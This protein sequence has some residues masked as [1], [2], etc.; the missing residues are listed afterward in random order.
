[1][2]YTVLDA[3]GQEVA[4]LHTGREEAEEIVAAWNKS[5]AS[6]R[7]LRP[8]QVVERSYDTGYFLVYDHLGHEFLS[9]QG[10]AGT[11][12]WTR[13]A[14]Y[15]ARFSLDQLRALSAQLGL[16]N[17]WAVPSTSSALDTTRLDP[18]TGYASMHWTVGTARS[19]LCSLRRCRHERDELPGPHHQAPR[20]GRKHYAR[21]SRA[22]HREG[23]AADGPLRDLGGHAG[24]GSRP[25][26][27]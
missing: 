12:C 16:S 5:K 20:Q 9:H 25:H 24:R 19:R 27:R 11:A 10:H 14:R 21:G 7:W 3:S 17:Y 6:P 15:A 2:Y 18:S 8:M 23:A 4:N 22:L 13:K 1:M 26:P